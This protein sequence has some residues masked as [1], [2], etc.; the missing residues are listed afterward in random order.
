[1]ETQWINIV[2][3][4]V[5]IG[6]GSI[7]TG[8]FTFIGLRYS[9]KSQQNK[10]LFEHKIKLLEQCT[11]EIEDYFI[12]VSNILNRIAGITK[13]RKMDDTENLPITESQWKSIKERD[14]LLIAT[15]PKRTYAISKLRL[16]KAEKVVSKLE[17]CIRV[18]KILRDR[19]IFEK[20]MHQYDEISEF[21]NQ[22]Y[23]LKSE[24]YAELSDFYDSLIK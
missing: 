17:E 24:V 8:F 14:D 18:E 2:D 1:M 3:T 12:S 5:K 15:W 7:I 20:N 23:I 11:G 19:I 6:L 16:M 9:H 21:R 10:Y 4:A 22:Y 13:R